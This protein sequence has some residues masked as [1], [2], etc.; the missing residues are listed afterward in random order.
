MK[1]WTRDRFS[2][3]AQLCTTA[4]KLRKLCVED[5]AYFFDRD[6]WI[7]QFIY[8]FLRDNTLPDAHD[9]LRE[10]YCEASF[11][12]IGLLRHA[13]ESKMIGDDAMAA[14]V[15]ASTS[16]AARLATTA[17]PSTTKPNVLPTRP[18]SSSILKKLSASGNTN[19]STPAPSAAHATAPSKAP[20]AATAPAS[21][22]KY[23]E[24]PD[25][26]GFTS[27]KTT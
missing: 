12:R 15:L 4:P 21:R 23:S 8:A 16:A 20:A 22:D 1:I 18:V 14:S 6:A 24:L 11:Y 2:I 27:K 10:L 17:S 25:P 13:I 5:D 19:A 9:V 7:F 26:F 3:L